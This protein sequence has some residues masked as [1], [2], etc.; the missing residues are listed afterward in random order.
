[1]TFLH[2]IFPHGQAR[3]ILQSCGGKCWPSL[4]DSAEQQKGSRSQAHS[5]L[6]P[7]SSTVT[8]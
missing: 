4:Q 3:E 7:V 2:W 5:G 8:M 1:M 6:H